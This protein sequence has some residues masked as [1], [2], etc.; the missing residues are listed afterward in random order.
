MAE[1][2]EPRTQLADPLCP[3]SDHRE[4][5][6]KPP[7]EALARW[8]AALAI[9]A[10][11]AGYFFNAVANQ[12]LCRDV[13]TGADTARQAVEVCG[14]PGLLNLVPFAV[15]IAILLWPDLGELAITGVVTLTR[16]V[17]VQEV[18]Q[19]AVESRLM[20]VDQHLT[21]LALLA[22][23]Q[24]QGQ[25]QTAAA[26]LNIYAPDQGD[27]RRGI[28]G[29]ESDRDRPPEPTLSHEMDPDE[30][31]RLLGVFLHEYSR[32]EPYID[33]RWGPRIRAQRGAF[34]P[35][36]ER[37]VTQWNELFRAEIDAIRRTRNVAVH[38]TD[39]VS[40]E[41]LQGAIENV[42]ELARILHDRLESLLDD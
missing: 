25:A 36:R 28:V 23:S 7:R 21:Q 3:G 40:A 35:H 9:A 19:D 2:T 24:S 5:R 34:G 37:L 33:R 18:R 30:H 39:T 38:E 20:Q 15:L 26:T 32:L 4:P 29:K 27:V 16:R 14:P 17:H 13:L 42:R 31:A 22:Q 1:A 8:V 12:S 6:E 41:T 11:A 10:A